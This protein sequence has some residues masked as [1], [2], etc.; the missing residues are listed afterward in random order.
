[1]IVNE[2]VISK[3]SEFKCP[4]KI[5]GVAHY[6]KRELTGKRFIYLDNVQDPGNVGTIIRTALSFSYD[7]LILSPG[8]ASIYN[9]KVIQASKGGV[10]R[11]PIFEGI[12]LDSLKEQGY[13]VIST[14]LHGAVD[15]LTFKPAEKFILVFGNEGQGI[16]LDTLHKSDALIKIEMNNIDSLNVAVA[17]GILMNH[18]R[19]N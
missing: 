1:M 16:S 14:A 12:S 4:S 15:Y 7:A 5:L 6:E 3:L 18:Y 10:F 19:G 17:A 13:Q 11:L 2:S 9:E 8:S